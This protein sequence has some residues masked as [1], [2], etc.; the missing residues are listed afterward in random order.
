VGS[1]LYIPAWGNG[2]DHQKGNTWDATAHVQILPTAKV[3]FWC[4]LSHGITSTSIHALTCEL[5][6]NQVC[7]ECIEWYFMQNYTEGCWKIYW[8]RYFVAAT[9]MML[10]CNLISTQLLVCYPPHYCF[11]RWIFLRWLCGVAGAEKFPLWWSLWKYG[12]LMHASCPWGWD[13]GPSIWSRKAPCDADRMQLATQ[14]IMS[15]V[16]AVGHKSD[17]AHKA[18]HVVV[19]ACALTTH[20]LYPKP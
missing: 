17:E 19:A 11:N 2:A 20:E 18:L 10:K 5:Y 9:M 14:S 1:P 16:D 3:L 12:R 7:R 6:M 4:H 13:P 15:C 8:N